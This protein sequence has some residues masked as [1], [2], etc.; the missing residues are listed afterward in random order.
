MFEVTITK[1]THDF[2]KKTTATKYKNA[3]TTVKGKALLIKILTPFEKLFL[4]S[5]LDKDTICLIE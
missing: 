5:S 4:S 3:V 2:D 1:K